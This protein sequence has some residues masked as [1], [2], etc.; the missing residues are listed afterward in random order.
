VEE[1]KMSDVVIVA[2]ARTPVGAFAGALSSVP[3]DYLGQITITAV[4]ERAGIAPADVDEVILG[5]VLTAGTG[6]NP[7]RIAAVNA[8]IPV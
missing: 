8:G 5:Q 2:A 7:A 6:Q 1:Y 3:A 4:L